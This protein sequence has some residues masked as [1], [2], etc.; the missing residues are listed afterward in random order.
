M[1]DRTLRSRLR[2]LAAI[3]PTVAVVLAFAL[4]WKLIVLAF[5]IPP[6]I[7]PPP[8][9]AAA[10][11]VK[12]A[13]ALAVA[14][15]LTLRNALAGLVVA[16]VLAVSLAALF[17]TSPT[18]MRAVL[19]IV[20]TLRTAPVLAIAPILI[21]IFGRGVGVAVAVVV[22]V[23]FFPIMVNAMKGFSSTKA[24]AL[25]L[26]H[27]LGASA[28][29]T[30]LKVRLPFALPF[31]FAG[32]RSAATAAMLAAM[33]AEWLS[34]APGLGSMILDASAMKK[35]ALLWAAVLVSMAA[36]FAIYAITAAAERHFT[37]WRS[38]R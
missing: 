16:L 14:L 30:F 35:S 6:Y 37:S 19:P 24:N 2:G 29:S 26:M 15:T 32:L 31:I 4:A 9:T 10:A 34:G 18:A 1:A 38:T 8:E 17:V 20:V 21:M 3:L 22:I 27:V 11:V 33:L 13:G 7:L 5:A 28:T 23:C 25:D 36:A 12:N